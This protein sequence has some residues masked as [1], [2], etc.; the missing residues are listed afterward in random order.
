[1]NH[2]KPTKTVPSQEEPTFERGTKSYE[3]IIK[4]VKWAEQYYKN[5]PEVRDG[6]QTSHVRFL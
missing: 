4:I 5:H 1:M 6:E 2:K 3:E